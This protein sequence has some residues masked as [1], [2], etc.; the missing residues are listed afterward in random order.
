MTLQLLQK[1][2]LQ[3]K[4]VPIHISHPKRMSSSR[5]LSVS[6]GATLRWR[7]Y[8]KH[9]NNS[10][11]KAL[12]YRGVVKKCLHPTLLEDPKQVQH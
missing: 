9:Q 8:S 7:L 12:T 10:L 2:S 6:Y 1:H 5:I 3:N 4:Q 11:E